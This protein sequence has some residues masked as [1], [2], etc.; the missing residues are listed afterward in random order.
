M[1]ANLEGRHGHACSIETIGSDLA[2]FRNSVLTLSVTLQKNKIFIARNRIT[3]Q[4]A[5]LDCSEGAIQG[6]PFFFS[7]NITIQQ[8]VN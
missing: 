8:Q 2:V 6:H 5:T 7:T 4:A 1:G 3:L